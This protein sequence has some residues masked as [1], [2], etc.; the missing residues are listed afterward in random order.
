[1][2]GHPLLR[3]RAVRQ[4]FPYSGLRPLESL[5]AAIEATQPRIIIPCDDRGVGHLHELHAHA[6]AQG[7]SGRVLMGL[8][9]RSLGPPESYTVVSN[10]YELLKLAAEEG[11]LVPPTHLVGTTADLEAWQK[12]HSFPFVL[13][14]D[15]TYGGRGVRIAQTLAQ[16]EQCFQELTNLFSAGRVIK[17]LCVNRDPFW[18]R[19]YWSRFRPPVIVQSHIN[20][21][22]ANCAVVCWEGRVLSGISVEVVSAEETTGPACVVHVVENRE[23]MH[24]AERIAGRL[25]LSGFFGLDFMIEDES[26]AAYLIEMNPRCTPVCHLQLGSGRDMIGALWAQLSGRPATHTPAV[27]ENEQIAYF[28]QARNCEH[29]LLNAS[30]FDIPEN[31][32]EL[33]RELLDPWPE[34]TLIFRTTNYLYHFMTSDAEH[35]PV[36]ALNRNPK[37]AA[38]PVS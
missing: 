12:Q 23:M 15:G 10:R 30:F 36:E 26:E 18:L 33:V 14:A 27:T 21:H 4:V 37:R 5:L 19:S 24:A 29:E 25:G 16:S 3:T 32:P 8:I 13:K 7:P 2:P 34:R 20:G 35:K 17:R 28:P 6:R 1:M 22:P 9:E 11:L 31:E 38:K